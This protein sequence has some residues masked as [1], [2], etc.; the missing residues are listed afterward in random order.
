MTDL[1]TEL[2]SATIKISFTASGDDYDDGAGKNAKFLLFL[3]VS[4]GLF[5]S[6]FVRF[7]TI[8]YVKAY[9]SLFLGFLKEDLFI[10]LPIIFQDSKFSLLYL[11][12]I[13]LH[14]YHGLF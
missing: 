9:E 3:V 11:P 1:K 14:E 8:K 10:F 4:I 2:Y 13:T 12:K 5:L 6:H 7:C